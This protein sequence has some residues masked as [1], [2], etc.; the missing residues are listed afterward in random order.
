MILLWLC[1]AIEIMIRLIINM[2]YLFQFILLAIFV[3]LIIYLL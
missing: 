3:C 2:F 1:L